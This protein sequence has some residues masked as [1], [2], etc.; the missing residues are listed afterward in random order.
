MDED[1]GDDPDQE[2]QLAQ[3]AGMAALCDMSVT[4]WSPPANALQLT[5]HSVCGAADIR[6]CRT[7]QHLDVLVMFELLTSCID[8]GHGH[9]CILDAFAEC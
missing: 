4:V 9:A 2:A 6:K 3:H 5:M 7:R 8:S 1:M